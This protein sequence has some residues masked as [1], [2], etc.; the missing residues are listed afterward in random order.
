MVTPGTLN[1]ERTDLYKIHNVVQNTI[2]SYPKELIIGILRDEFS[3]DS[4]YH[5]VSDQFGF[6]KVVDHTDLPLDAGI[7]DDQ[8]TRIYIG[9]TFH[10]G[11]ILYP[12][13]FV[14]MTSA[15][16]V[17]IS[18]SRNKGVI[19][20]SKTIVSDE[21]GNQ[22][23]YL[24]PTHIDLAGAW[25]GSISIDI[26]TRDIISRDHLSSILML[27]FTDIRFESLRKAGVLVKSGNPSLGGLSETEDRQQ[28]KLYKATINLDI[29]SEWRRLIPIES[30]VEKI[31]LCVNFGTLDG[32][33]SESPNLQIN[34]SLSL[35]D[36][37][38][39]L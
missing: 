20:Y 39:N 12:A 29:R 7:N 31:N 19:N 14:K 25:E 34:Q 37:I 13:L 1:I 8:V 23:V 30:V 32:L 22:K 38:E 24:T 18:M 3:K 28:E 15:K 9:E 11:V 35:F 17:P 33:A 6:P 26:W 4:Y 10:Q 2:M 36:K 5:Y 16:S 21:L 27:L